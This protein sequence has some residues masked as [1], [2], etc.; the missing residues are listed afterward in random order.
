MTGL[1]VFAFLVMAVMAGSI[2]VAAVFLGGWPGKIAAK[3]NH[4]QAEA[5]KMCG[6]I[7]VLT[8]GLLWPLAFIW[9]YTNPVRTA[10]A[11]SSDNALQQTINELTQRIEA[12]ETEL[13]KSA[14]RE[15]G[16]QS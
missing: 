5:I 14:T 16:A 8:L 12:L 7:G 10:Q 6:W 9:A 4:H 15:G 13:A 2:I 11:G 1:D 3:R